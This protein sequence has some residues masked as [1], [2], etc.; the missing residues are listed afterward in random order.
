[1]SDKVKV[2]EV[3]WAA[4]PIFYVHVR[5]EMCQSPVQAKCYAFGANLQPPITDLYLGKTLIGA[6]L[7][8]TGR[9]FHDV[10]LPLEAIYCIVTPQGVGKFWEAD[11]PSHEVALV[12]RSQFRVIEGGRSP[13]PSIGPGPGP[14]SAA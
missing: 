11:A 2:F 4:A 7:S 1:M 3:M 10:M 5:P 8:F 13:T 12:R 14:R 6:R 9:G